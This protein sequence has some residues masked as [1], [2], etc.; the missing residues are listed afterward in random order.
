MKRFIVLVIG[1]LS[2]VASTQAISMTA[3]DKAKESSGQILE[4][5]SQE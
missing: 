5:I 1:V 3:F 4:S 2:S